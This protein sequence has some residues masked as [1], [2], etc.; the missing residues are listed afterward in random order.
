MR[1]GVD[2]RLL[3]EPLTG[4]GRYTLELSKALQS[5]DAQFRFY[6]PKE[7]LYVDWLKQNSGIRSANMTNRLGKM[8]WSQTLLPKWSAEERVDVFWGATHRLPRYLSP[9]IA[10][11]VT[12]HDLVW[13]HAGQTMR[14]LSRFLES[15]L[16]PEAIR[17]ADR[18]MADSQS[19]ADAICAEFVE[20]RSKVRHVPLGATKMAKPDSLESLDVLGITRQYYLFVGTL[21]PRKNLLRMLAA[22]AKL[23]PIL[24]QQY[25]F[26]IAGGRGWGKENLDQQLMRLGLSEHVK[27]VGYVTDEQLST[28][29][30]H[31]QFLAMPS[32]YEGFGLPVIE[33]NSL[34]TP[35]LVSNSSSLPEVVG[36]AGLL[37]NPVD[38][39]DM[40]QAIVT[41]L[42]NAPRRDFLASL[43]EQNAAKFTWERSAALAMQVFDEARRE[44]SS[45]A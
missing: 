15:R 1:V 2:A 4:I 14:P 33:A 9:K 39:D 40:H 23:E 3:S 38:I 36:D 35:A 12:I 6:A 13:K 34:G 44:R 24:K 41:L 19:T 28:L 26:V 43:A 8:L 20:A 22:A 17:L 18:I 31:A 30:K 5:H 29:Y 21:E 7:P 11:V 16:M 32:L 25:Q 42:T 45:N 37:V 27:L 10:R